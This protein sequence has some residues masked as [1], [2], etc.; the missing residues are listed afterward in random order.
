MELLVIVAV[1][2]LIFTVL[3]SAL[4]IPLP[5]LLKEPVFPATVNVP[6]PLL[7]VPVLVNA[8]L[9]PFIVTT[10]FPVLKVPILLKVFPSIVN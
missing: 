8:P 5:L 6:D 3:E 7:N 4:K 10:P 1:S 9:E 2:P